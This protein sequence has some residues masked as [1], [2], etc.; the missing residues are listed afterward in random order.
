MTTTSP[1]L[2]AGIFD[3]IHQLTAIPTAEIKLTD[4]LSGDLGMDSVTSM[5]L[6]G[7]LDETYGIEVEMEE[8]KDITTVQEVVDLATKHHAT[9]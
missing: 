8:T 6:I 5:E 9:G 4:S 7:L 3:I 2:H 1:D